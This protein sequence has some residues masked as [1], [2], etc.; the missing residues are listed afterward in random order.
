M[1]ELKDISHA[2]ADIK[3][4]ILHGIYFNMIRPAQLC[5]DAGGNLFHRLQ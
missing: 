5:I 2:V 1:Q 4:T 3:I